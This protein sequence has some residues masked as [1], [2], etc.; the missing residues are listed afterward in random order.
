MLTG[1]ILS[2]GFGTRLKPLTEHIPKALVPICGASLLERALFQCK[3]HGMDRIG[4]NAYHFPEQ[5]QSYAERSEIPF[6]LLKETG[7]IRGTGGALHFARDFLSGSETF[8]TCNVDILAEIDLGAL[9]RQF[10]SE[11]CAA[12]LV[13]IPLTE[14]GS[15][16][17]NRHTSAYCGAKTDPGASGDSAEFLGMV[18][19]RRHFLSFVRPEDFSILPI[20]KRAQEMGQKVKVLATESHYWKDAG[21]LRSLAEIHFDL[22]KKRCSL[23]VPSKMVVDTVNKRAFPSHFSEH[24]I[25]RL[26][27]NVWCQAP[28]VPKDTFL[29]NAI[30]F[31]GATL[32]PG[33]HVK[34]T[35]ISPWEKIQFSNC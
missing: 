10:L 24:E 31:D 23:S 33:E 26:G 21:T 12:G 17:Y 13:A 2:A 30:V 9:Y 14:G 1:F 8:F 4:V 32:Q 25:A 29:E 35:I 16:Y 27:P 19:Y 34:N 5:M 20:W 6:D 22:L 7:T 28:N 11:D 18:F 15:I 3:R